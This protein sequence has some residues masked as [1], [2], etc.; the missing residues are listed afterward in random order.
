MNSD[1]GVAPAQEL[2]R[3]PIGDRFAAVQQGGDFLLSSLVS[4]VG[5]AVTGSIAGEW[6]SNLV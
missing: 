4:G 2:L 1:P 3:A 6:K 5:L